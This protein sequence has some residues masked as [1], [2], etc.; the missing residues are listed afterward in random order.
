MV[1]VLGCFLDLLQVNRVTGFGTVNQLPQD[2]LVSLFV[3]HLGERRKV[4]LWHG[5]YCYLG[6][7]SE[8]CL[9]VD[10]VNLL[11][12]FLKQFGRCLSLAVSESDNDL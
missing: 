3:D 5:F 12:L 11:G 8:V 1:L 6:V 2:G 9:D 7:G 4:D 10:S